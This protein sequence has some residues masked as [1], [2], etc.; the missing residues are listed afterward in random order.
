VK[1]R[2]FTLML[3]A[4]PLAAVAAFA[5]EDY[6]EVAFASAGD[7]LF[8]VD[9]R[10]HS[11]L[12]RIPLPA[13]AG[14]V[15][16]GMFPYDRFVLV[17]SPRAGRVTLVDAKRLRTV[18]VFMIGGHPSGIE[19]S[20][21]GKY[22]YVADEQ[23]GSVV[24]LN[25]TRRRIVGR[26]SVAAK[27]QGLAVTPDG[28][29]LW[30]AS[31]RS[32]TILDTTRPSQA[33]VLGRIRAPGAED[34]AFACGGRCVWVSYRSSGWLGSVDPSSHRLTFHRV[35]AGMRM[36]S[37]MQAGRAGR[38]LWVADRAGSRVRAVDARTGRVVRSYPLAGGPLRVANGINGRIVIASH[39]G[40]SVLTPSFWRPH[41]TG[42]HLTSIPL[43]LSLNGLAVVLVPH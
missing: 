34:V 37:G 38:L 2:F 24:L 23:R 41:H 8:A 18:H 22:A 31:R 10:A 16:A 1:R 20:P 25:L 12:R 33:R 32:V 43:G 7:R 15:A 42:Y 39:A 14:D 21:Q 26:F 3:V 11:I 19:V 13:G 27:P 36:V 6:R 30:V 29:Q 5:K 28:R 17:S 9:L 4:L 35:R 40:I